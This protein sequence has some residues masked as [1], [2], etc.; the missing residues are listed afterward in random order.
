MGLSLE[1]VWL[2]GSV[3]QYWSGKRELLIVFSRT[4]K[5]PHVLNVK[6]GIS[7]RAVQSRKYPNLQLG[8]C[9]ST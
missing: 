9:L 1:D 5:T 7:L 2:G 3:V 4:V 6:C 8:K